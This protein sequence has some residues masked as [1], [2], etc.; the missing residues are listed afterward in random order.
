MTEDT[1]PAS[2]P[3]INLDDGMERVRGKWPTYK[4]LLMLFYK[5]YKT[6]GDTMTSLLEQGD[7][8]KAMILAHSLKGVGGTIGA[9]RFYKQA[10]LMESAC[11]SGSEEAATAQ[12][13]PFRNS[14]D[15]VIN[16]LA[17]L[18]KS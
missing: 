11:R 18:D 7:F 17:T 5:E 15:E 12:L 16:G 6:C 10:A 8:E 4:R 3:G 1:I 2:L 9:Q 14:L 13:T